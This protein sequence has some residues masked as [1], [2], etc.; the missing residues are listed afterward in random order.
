MGWSCMERRLHIG[1]STCQV[2]FKLPLCEDLARSV[3][4]EQVVA[5]RSIAGK[6]HAMGSRLLYVGTNANSLRL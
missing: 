2:R 5:T 1:P 4:D 3:S 6:L